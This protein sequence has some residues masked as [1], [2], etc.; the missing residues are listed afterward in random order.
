MTEN[1]SNYVSEGEDSTLLLL[2]SDESILSRAL[3]CVLSTGLLVVACLGC[4][5]NTIAFTTLIRHPARVKRRTSEIYLIHISLNDWLF[6]LGL[7]PQAF[8]MIAK[9]DLG[10]TGC[11]IVLGM[12]NINLTASVLFV[13]GRVS[14]SVYGISKINKHFLQLNISDDDRSIFSSTLRAPKDIFSQVASKVFRSTTGLLY[15]DRLGYFVP[16]RLAVLRGTA[17]FNRRWTLFGT[18]ALRLQ[19]HL[20]RC[21]IVPL[22]NAPAMLLANPLFHHSSLQHRSSMFP[23]QTARGRLKERTQQGFTPHVKLKRKSALRIPRHCNTTRIVSTGRR[24]LT[25]ISAFVTVIVLICWMPD[26]ILSFYVGVAHEI[27][28][29]DPEHIPHSLPLAI[30]ITKYVFKVLLYC[31]AV[32]NPIIYCFMIRSFQTRLHRVMKSRN[33]RAKQMLIERRVI[34]SSFMETSL[35]PVS[36]TATCH[37]IRQ[38]QSEIS[39]PF[40]S[41]N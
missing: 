22:Y 34:L 1:I 13:T 40:I 25:K 26:Q 39:I 18:P 4:V 35:A 20:A 27:E 30:L 33:H 8:A 24:I 41:H 29:E 10:D 6:S 16:A 2:N 14:C 12:T 7:F 11:K 31:T 21:G 38:H 19:I 15:L 28:N 3:V 23:T 9:F 5:L 32:I 36:C 37:Y 17:A